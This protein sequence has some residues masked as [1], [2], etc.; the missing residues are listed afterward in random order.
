MDDP[1]DLARGKNPPFPDLPIVGTFR[2]IDPTTLDIIDIRDMTGVTHPL[3]LIPLNDRPRSDVV[4]N[5]E[6][7]SL[8]ILIPVQST[9]Q[10][11]GILRSVLRQPESRI[12]GAV[13]PLANRITPSTGPGIAERG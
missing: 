10:I 4:V 1:G 3:P 9:A 13:V 8:G 12:V 5:T 7:L 2:N 6:T 11:A